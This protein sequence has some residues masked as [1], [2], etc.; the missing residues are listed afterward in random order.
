MSVADDIAGA[1]SGLAS[2]FGKTATIQG[3]ANIP[4]TSGPNLNRSLAY[5]D[6]GI[7]AI[8]TVTLWYRLDE[9]P[10]P[11]V[12]GDVQFKDLAFQ[13]QSFTQHAATWEVVVTQVVA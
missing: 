9:G 12:N 1:F 7:N 8:Q 2:V 13:V 11:I 6:G 4:V 3:Q 10:Q 5:G